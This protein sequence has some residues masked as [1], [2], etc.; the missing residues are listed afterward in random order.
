MSRRVLRALP[1]LLLTSVPAFMTAQSSSAQS[2]APSAPTP[3]AAL[4]HARRLLEATPLVDGHNDLP[5]T[6][7]ESKTAPLDVDAYDLR[8]RTA[9]NT[10]LARLKEGRVGVQF[11]SVYVPGEYKDS[12]FARVQLEQIDV[13]R[14]VIA[15]YPDRFVLALTADDAE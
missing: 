3:A 11:W 2:S 8:Q 6:I 12:G 15:R 13:A 10:D 14:R 9:G 7:R 1:I 4:A 5:W